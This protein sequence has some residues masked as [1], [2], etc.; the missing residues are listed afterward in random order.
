MPINDLT[1]DEWYAMEIASEAARRWIV[2]AALSIKD[3]KPTPTEYDVRWPNH[4]PQIPDIETHV[5]VLL[6]ALFAT[7]PPRGPRR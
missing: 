5:D 2:E 1:R 7:A 3:G 4:V 6:N